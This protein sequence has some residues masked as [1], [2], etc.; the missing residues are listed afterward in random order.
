MIDYNQLIQELN[1]AC[2][3]F[4]NESTFYFHKKEPYKYISTGSNCSQASNWKK[5][6]PLPVKAIKWFDNFWIYSEIKLL[7][8][9]VILTISIFQGEPD[10]SKT[11]LLRAEWDSYSNKMESHPQPHWHITSNIALENTFQE[12]AEVLEQDGFLAS[13]EDEKTKVINMNKFH[14]PMCANWLN[15]H[16]DKNEVNHQNIL[17]WFCG[18]LTDVETQLKYCK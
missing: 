8:T 12:Y 2:S 11:Q 9:D 10:D 5:G 4:F 6:T 15:Q 14:F 16:Y 13:L 18:I 3:S 1:K 7:D 17:K